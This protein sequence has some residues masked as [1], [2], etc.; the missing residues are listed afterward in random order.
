MARV[1]VELLQPILLALVFVVGVIVFAA[2]SAVGQPP[3]ETSPSGSGL[4]LRAA[5]VA[6]PVTIV[7]TSQAFGY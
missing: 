6:G 4:V 7:T 1:H 2:G 3:A 5:P